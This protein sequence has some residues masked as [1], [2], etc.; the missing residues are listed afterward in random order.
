MFSPRDA[1]GYRFH[2]LHVEIMMIAP[3]GSMRPQF[4]L[5]K[6]VVEQ[7]NASKRFPLNIECFTTKDPAIGKRKSAYR[8]C[9]DGS[10]PSTQSHGELWRVLQFRLRFTCALLSHRKIDQQNAKE[11]HLGRRLLA[12]SR[13]QEEDRTTHKTAGGRPNEQSSDRSDFASEK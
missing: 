4:L 12:G 11:R 8:P 6:S 1:R 9:G 10:L 2:S 13:K 5:T 3:R 7:R